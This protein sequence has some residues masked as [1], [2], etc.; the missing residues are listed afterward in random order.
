MPRWSRRRSRAAVLSVVLAVVAAVAAYALTTLS[1]AQAAVKAVYIP[2]RWV[3]T[4]EVPWTQSRTRESTNFILLWG[5]LAGTDPRSAPSQYRFDPDNM[6]SQLE[7]LR[8]LREHDAVH[9]GDRVPG[10]VQDHCDRD[11]DLVD[12]AAA[13]RLG[14]RRV[15]DGVVGVINI[16]PGGRRPG[17]GVWPTSWAT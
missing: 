11:P 9:A 14:H 5:D 13:G 15:T 12:P 7:T 2:S 17:P 3:S 4:G 8:L 1:P 16:A 6:L 10:P